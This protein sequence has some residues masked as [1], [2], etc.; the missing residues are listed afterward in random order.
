MIGLLVQAAGQAAV[1]SQLEKLKKKASR[2]QLVHALKAGGA[3][4]KQALEEHAPVRT[5]AV[6]G[7]ALPPGALKDDIHITVGTGKD[8]SVSVGPGPKTAK[9]GALV[10]RGHSEVQPGSARLTPKSATRGPGKEIGHVSAHP[11]VRPAWEES[12]QRAAQAVLA[13]LKKEVG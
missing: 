3:V 7:D 5:P 11:W 6:S 9:V 12:S 4:L 1:K 13:D 10:E 2:D 8:P